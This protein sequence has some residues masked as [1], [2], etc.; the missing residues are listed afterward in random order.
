MDKTIWTKLVLE[1][2]KF[3]LKIMGRKSFEQTMTWEQKYVD[4]KNL[5]KYLLEKNVLDQVGHGVRCFGRKVFGRT[6]YRT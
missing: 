6:L 5:D 2:V 3:G 4:V 1:Q